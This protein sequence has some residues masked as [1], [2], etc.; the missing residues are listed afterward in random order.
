MF[1]SAASRGRGNK[2]ACLPPA[3]VNSD[4]IELVCAKDA[5]SKTLPAI[6]P[7]LVILIMS[8]VGRV[9]PGGAPVIHY[10]Y[11]RSHGH[12][13]PRPTDVFPGH[14]MVSNY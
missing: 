13:M 7:I 8:P 10:L 6:M 1:Y 5:G 11:M 2:P 12:D 14:I 4:G 3:F 9:A